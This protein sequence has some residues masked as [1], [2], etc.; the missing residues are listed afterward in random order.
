MNMLR[1]GK[2]AIQH[3]L[4][5]SAFWQFSLGTVVVAVITALAAMVV[6]FGIS[7]QLVHKMMEETG[8]TV[9]SNAV[10]YIGRSRSNQD[11]YRVVLFE[12][13]K[14]LL[15]NTITNAFDLLEAFEK[16]AVSL[17]L[18]AE[19][20]KK[21]AVGQLQL[22]KAGTKARLLILGGD[23]R[24]LGRRN[25][26][27]GAE[28]EAHGPIATMARQ[29]RDA[30]GE[31]IIEVYQAN[32]AGQSPVE[33]HL[34]LARYYAPWNLTLVADVDLWKNSGLL[35]EQARTQLD[36]LRARMGEIVLGR[37]GYVFVLNQHCDIL[38]HPTLA[39]QN[40]TDEELQVDG[41]SLCR[42]IQKTAIKPW[43]SNRLSYNWD[44]TGQARNYVFPKLAWCTR[45]PTTG[46][47]VGASVY[48]EEVEEDLPRYVL[49]IFFPAL[50]AIFVLGGALAVLLRKLLQPVHNLTLVCQEVSGG[51]LEAMA[52]EDAFG[53]VGFLAQHFNVMV[54]TV[55]ELI[56]LDALRQQEL[57]ALNISL[58]KKVQER[59]HD[60][61]QKTEK[62]E[63]ANLRLRELDKLKSG[64]LSSVSHELRTPLTS[65]MGFAKLIERDFR[66]HA[67]NAEQ[68]ENPRLSKIAKRIDKNLDIIN[69]EA[70]RLTSMINKLL[71]LSSVESGSAQMHDSLF[72]LADALDDC[73]LQL[74]QRLKEYPDILLCIAIE[75]TLPP[76]M[77]DM[78][79]IQQVFYNLIENSLKFTQQG[80]ITI[81]ACSANGWIQVRIKDTGMGLDK[82]N[83]LRVFESFHQISADEESL[84]S[85][86]KGSGLGL[87]LCKSIIDHYAGLIWCESEPGKGTEVI[88]EFPSAIVDQ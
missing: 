9:L 61:K 13:D 87:S 69:T 44:R 34:A 52:S 25:G 50:G 21:A 82:I 26:E 56:E 83:L 55:R 32:A 81:S 68:C 48:V 35:R 31:E 39:G 64:L 53:E 62:L 8:Y 84:I 7:R 75:K 14:E 76:L 88:F 20:A 2:N 1:M 27:T 11:Q 4:P 43:G 12:A 71:D 66:H 22:D 16:E 46:W 51:N 63:E 37:S 65:I 15:R 3:V 36:E 57:E 70:L 77:A 24:I 79:R 38:V 10:D 33:M 6:A 41:R 73:L 59:T 54:R 60:L 30:A 85:K 17:D 47:Y 19:E 23:L 74:D 45:E 42:A 72:N 49:L 80:R 18:P 29:A 78:E 67:K 28:S 86:P 40:L 58:E 5:K